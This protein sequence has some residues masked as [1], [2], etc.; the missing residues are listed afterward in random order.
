MVQIPGPRLK[1]GGNPWGL[2]GGGGERGD[3][4]AWN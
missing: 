4:G 1:V 2:L 3:V